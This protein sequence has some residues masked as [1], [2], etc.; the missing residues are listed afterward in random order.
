VAGG[1]FYK[2]TGSGNDFV[3]LDGRDHRLADW[4]PD[5][6]RS[7]C[8]RRMGVGADGVVHLELSGPG[9]LRM[10][11][12]NSDGSHAE[13]CGN[14]ALCSTR[15][16]AHLGLVSG[17]RI[18]LDTDAGELESRTA[19]PGWA[20]ELRFPTAELPGPL[21]LDLL[22]GE[23][24]AFQGTVGVPHSV[25]VVDDIRAVDL[26]ARGREI[27]FDP[28]VGPAGSNVNFVA[29][30]D[31]PDAPWAMRTY[32][33]GVEGE[34]LACGTG[35]VAVALALAAAGQCDLPVRIRSRS[36]CVYSVAGA[37]EADGARD[38]WLCGEARVVFV[39]EFSTR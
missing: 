15:L 32:E 28:A 20:A 11:Y 34:T 26:A 17:Q 25:L 39:G 2:M 36:G 12:F 6:I 13:M 14:A 22:P 27:R 21:G 29:R 16:A 8:Q 10:R 33:R 38:I 35:T 37:I 5:R 24:A 23:L 9:R 3:F 1:Q 4:G 30:Q 19:G 18:V 7:V 31:D